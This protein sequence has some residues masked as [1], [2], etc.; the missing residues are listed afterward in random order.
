LTDLDDA[1]RVERMDFLDELKSRSPPD[2]L[3]RGA[4]MLV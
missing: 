2:S 4:W 1:V 3:E